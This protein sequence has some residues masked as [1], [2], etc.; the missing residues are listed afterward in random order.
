M[1]IDRDRA[2]MMDPHR[3]EYKSVYRT[4]FSLKKYRT[5]PFPVNKKEF[6]YLKMSIK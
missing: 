5:H 1:C 2:Y 4:D 6:D 3:S